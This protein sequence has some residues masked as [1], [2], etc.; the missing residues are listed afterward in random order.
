ML[1]YS[2]ILFH[3][4]IA[5]GKRTKILERYNGFGAVSISRT[6]QSRFLY[7]IT[8]VSQTWNNIK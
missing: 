8:N 2:C 7:K 6:P 4:S 5:E 3:E 1:N